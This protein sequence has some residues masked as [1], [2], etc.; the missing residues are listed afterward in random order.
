MYIEN[1]MKIEDENVAYKIGNLKTY[2]KFKGEQ[3]RYSSDNIKD[4]DFEEDLK[5]LSDQQLKQQYW[6]SFNQITG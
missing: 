4:C 6:N 3:Q 5:I 2:K 1:T